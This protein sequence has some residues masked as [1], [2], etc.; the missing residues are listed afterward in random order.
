[1]T[2]GVAVD[3]RADFGRREVLRP[4]GEVWRPSPIV[5]AE[6]HVLDR[7]GEEVARETSFVRYAAGARFGADI[8]SGGEEF[9]VLAGSLHDDAGDY[10]ADIYVRNPV[11]TARAR[12]AGPDGAVLFVKL[13]QFAATDAQRV[14]IDTRAARWR[15]GMVPGLTVLPLH[16]HGGARRAGA[17]GAVDQVHA[18]SALG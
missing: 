8:H 10:P 7:L 12:W 15:Q 18:A 11:G 13:H 5:G 9:L 1:L 4:G 16:E 2:N 6:S 17:V 3:V 14:L